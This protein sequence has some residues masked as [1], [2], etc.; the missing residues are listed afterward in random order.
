MIQINSYYSPFN[1]T[2]IHGKYRNMSLFPNMVIKFQVGA[3]LTFR[4]LLVGTMLRRKNLRLKKY[5]QSNPQYSTICS[6]QFATVYK[7]WQ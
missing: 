1:V 5:I 4:M 3:F 6:Q 7:R 2:T